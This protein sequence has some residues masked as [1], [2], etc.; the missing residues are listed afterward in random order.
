MKLPNIKLINEKKK[1]DIW[2][3][4][5]YLMGIN[6]SNYHLLLYLQEQNVAT[7][8]QN[9]YIQGTVVFCLL[10]NS[11]IIVLVIQLNS[12]FTRP[13]HQLDQLLCCNCSSTFIKKYGSTVGWS[14][15]KLDKLEKDIERMVPQTRGVQDNFPSSTS[16]SS[17]LYF[18]LIKPPIMPHLR[19]S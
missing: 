12:Y 18:H 3:R 9:S 14:I 1:N 19:N 7:R 16:S 5:I 13:S 6:L 11:S 17:E 10:Q 15:D 2:Q 4:V 8:S